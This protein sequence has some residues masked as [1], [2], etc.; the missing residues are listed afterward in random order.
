MFGRTLLVLVAGI[1]L[2]AS[3]AT[4]SAKTKYKIGFEKD[5]PETTCTGTL[6]APSGAPIRG[7]FLEGEITMLWFEGGVLGYSAQETITQGDSQVTINLVGTADY[8]A[9]PTVTNVLGSVV[10]GSWLGRPLT[11]AL[12]RGS[13]ERVIGTTRFR[14]LLTI[15]ARD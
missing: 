6:L 14:G 2:V 7:S 3:P 4:A 10:G 15:T 11:G 9:E 8:N 1:A 5:C 13:A 12:V